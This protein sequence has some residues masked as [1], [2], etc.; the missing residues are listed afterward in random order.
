MARRSSDTA[1]SPRRPVFL[2]PSGNPERPFVGRLYCE[3]WDENQRNHPGP[4]S[5]TSSLLRETGSSRKWFICL[6]GLLRGLIGNER[7][8]GVTFPDKVKVSTRELDIQS[9]S[10]KDPLVCLSKS[11]RA[12]FTSAHVQRRWRREG[13]AERE[14][15]RERER[16]GW[17]QRHDA[18][19]LLFWG[20]FW[21]SA[22]SRR[23]R[24]WSLHQ[25]WGC[26]LI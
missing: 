11:I 17:R 5:H 4:G 10:T 12:C 25:A 13:G 19:F 15:D 6:K 23:T 18:P 14:V 24:R 7:G 9:G 26:P 3:D 8:D 22:P 16:I 2:L 21:I 20:V 1:L